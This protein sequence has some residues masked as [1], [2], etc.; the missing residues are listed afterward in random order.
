MPGPESPVDK[1]RL[2]RALQCGHEVFKT[3]CRSV[4]MGIETVR[5]VRTGPTAAAGRFAVRCP[6]RLCGSPLSS[7]LSF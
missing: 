7:A 3:R 6:S 2:A 1:T 5:L 4:C